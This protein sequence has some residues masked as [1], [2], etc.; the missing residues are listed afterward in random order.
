[1]LSVSRI[2]I[3]TMFTVLLVLTAVPAFAHFQT[4]LYAQIGSDS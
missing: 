4:D 2:R 1:M 3:I